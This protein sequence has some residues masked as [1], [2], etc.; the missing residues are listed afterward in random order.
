MMTP[1]LARARRPLA[2]AGLALGL[3]LALAAAAG[4]DDEALPTPAAPTTDSAPVA[5][6]AAP[7]DLKERIEVTF[8][9]YF[10]GL[11]VM[12]T[13][14]EVDAHDGD[15]DSRA[16]FRTAGLAGWLKDSR[17]FAAVFGGLD[18]DAMRPTHYEHRNLRSK[19]NRVIRIDF[20]DDEVVETI[21]PTFGSLGN[22]P[23]TAEQRL[24]SFDPITAFLSI[25]FE[26]GEDPCVRTIPVFD[27]K[28]RFDLTFEPVEYENIRVRGYDGPTWR[29]HVYLTPLAGY[30]P[31]DLG[32]P[33][34]YAR[35]LD[36]WLADLGDERWVPVR[37]R[38]TVSGVRVSV[39]ARRVVRE[40][41]PRDVET[42]LEMPFE[43]I[44]PD[45]HG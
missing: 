3:G 42:R 17:I 27:G 24:E 8:N 38:A 43:F 33:E 5:D 11:R 45:D 44:L 39:E 19:K 12:K 36:M 16:E 1:F 25:T 4:A 10:L 7:S 34:D 15:Y 35:P 13:H 6:E 2:A 31:E 9:G 26:G 28:Q 41:V 30:D 14:V 29:C 22:P 23:V 21:T 40:F 18:G 37:I 32:S 20:S